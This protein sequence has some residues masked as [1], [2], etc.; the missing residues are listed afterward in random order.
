ML[1]KRL[2]P[3]CLAASLL[4]G[5]S[6]QPSAEEIAARQQEAAQAALVLAEQARTREFLDTY[7]AKLGEIS[8]EHGLAVERRDTLLAVSIPVD[9]YFNVKRQA[10][11]L[12]PAS[13][14]R[15]AALSNLLKDDPQAAVL[16]VGHLDA[17]QALQYPRLSTQ[18]AQAI[19]A[20]FRLDGFGRERLMFKGVGGDHPRASNDN[21]EGRSQNRRVE[22]LLTLQSGLRHVLLSYRI[23]AL[24]GVQLGHIKSQ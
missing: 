18:Q 13:L 12:L 10:D 5:C 19:A 21:E 9:S 7:E 15:I 14:T 2:L 23:P 16:I 8:K 6:S 3:L 17:P 1:A 24:G 11:T 4:G 20:L 22:L